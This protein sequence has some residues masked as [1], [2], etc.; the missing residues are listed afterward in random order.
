MA[1]APITISIVTSVKNGEPFFRDTIDSITHQKYEHWNYLIIDAG[2]TDGS[3]EH[4]KAAAAADSRI[5]VEQRHGE[6]LYASL[7]WGLSQCKGDYLCWLNADDLYTPGAFS[8]LGRFVE[9]TKVPWITGL[10]ACWDEGGAL[11]FVRARAWHPAPLIKAGMFHLEAL[12]FLQQES[13]F[14]SKPLFE[15]LTDKERRTF[16]AQKLAGDF[17]LWKT[18]AGYAPLVTA[19]TVFGGFRQHRNNLSA[20]NMNDYIIAAENYYKHLSCR[21]F[22]TL[23]VRLYEGATNQVRENRH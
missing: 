19:P 1:A 4:A 5:R 11:R 12:G 20:N 8:A 15:R 18:F 9:Q 22:P 21:A 3:F 16:A 7:L 13:M 6:A 14:F 23:Y 2:S 17:Y 10:P